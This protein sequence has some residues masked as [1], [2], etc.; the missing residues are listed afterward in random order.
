MRFQLIRPN[1]AD[2]NAQFALLRPAFN[3]VNQAKAE[4]EFC[5]DAVRRKQASLYHLKGKGVSVRFVGMVTDDNSYLILAMTGRGLVAAAPTIIEAVKSQGYRQIKYH[6]VRR[7]MTRI[8]TRF[9][10]SITDK[11]A[12]DTVLSLLLEGD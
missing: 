10:F 1:R 3:G 7:G 2:I 11:T 6:T 9:G 5:C 12:H 8:L 4:F